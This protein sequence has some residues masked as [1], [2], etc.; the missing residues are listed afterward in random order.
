[1]TDSNATATLERMRLKWRHV[2]PRHRRAFIYDDAA[3][4]ALRLQSTLERDATWRMFCAIPT[5]NW[6]AYCRRDGVIREAQAVMQMMAPL[7]DPVDLRTVL[8]K[9]QI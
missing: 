2:N 4:R 5:R 1:M 3:R 8:P 7:Q 9:T 6:A